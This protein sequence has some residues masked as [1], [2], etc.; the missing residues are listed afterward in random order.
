MESEIMNSM[1]LYLNDLV[2]LFHYNSDCHFNVFMHSFTFNVNLH[3][4]K[5]YTLVEPSQPPPRTLV[6]A[7]DTA[8]CL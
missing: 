3:P 4:L 6:N 2:S 5:K 1:L 8:K 7:S